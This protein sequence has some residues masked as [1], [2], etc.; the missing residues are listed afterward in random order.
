MPSLCSRCV[1]CDREALRSPRKM[2]R[3][4]STGIF[5]YFVGFLRSI[6]TIADTLHGT[7]HVFQFSIDI[8]RTGHVQR[9]FQISS[10]VLQCREGRIDFRDQSIGILQS[11]MPS[12]FDLF[13]V[14]LTSG[15]F[16]IICN[17][18]SVSD[19]KWVMLDWNRLDFCRMSSSSFRRC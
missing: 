15:A 13:V 3:I 16:S 8:R 5:I 19:C 14:L 18:R 4:S 2:C 12:Y 7:G 11:D 6:E 1:R 9:S 10:K 17:S